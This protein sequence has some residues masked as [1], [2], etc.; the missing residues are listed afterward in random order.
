LETARTLQGEF[1]IEFPLHLGNAEATPFPDA[2]FDFAISEYGAVLWAD[3]EAWVPEADRILRPGGRLH[4]LTNH[5]LSALTSPD[6]PDAPDAPVE[7]RLLRPQFGMGRT[8]WAGETT[9]EFHPTHGDW[10]RLFTANGFEV[11]ELLEPQVPEGSSTS[12]AW[13]PYDWARRWPCEEIWKVRKR[14]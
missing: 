4:V 3:P 13:M 12:Y 10:I 6:D 5:V 1:G 11:I 8:V 2:S 9:V 14:G 7:E